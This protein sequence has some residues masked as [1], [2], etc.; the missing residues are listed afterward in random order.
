MMSQIVLLSLCASALI[1]TRQELTAQQIIDRVEQTMR[2]DSA[3]M[4]ASMQIV[5]PEW[6]RTVAFKSYDDRRT[7]RFFIHILSPVRDK[8]TTFLREDRNL[9][10]YLPRAEK[11]IRIPPSM[12][13]Q[14][15][16][17]S[18]FTNDDLV[19]ESSYVED[20]TH[21]LRGTVTIEGSECWHLVMVPKPDAPATWGRI[22]V[23]VTIDPLLPWR[24]DYYNQR[25]ELRKRMQM[26]D[27]K[28]MDGH[29]MPTRWIMTS[30]DKPGNATIISI[31]EIDF[32][33]KLPDRVFTQQYLRNPR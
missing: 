11:T 13:S 33:A 7:D 1:A 28:T 27:V 21:E 3:Y 19:K 14:S 23:Y 5:T 29:L 22:E 18:D 25:G 20:F 30:V 15:W 2:S 32:D 6:S 17:G 24:Y 8:D 4:A 9:W 31:D 26:S 12:M 10:M 16:M